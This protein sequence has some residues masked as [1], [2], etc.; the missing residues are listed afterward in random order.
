VL[1]VLQEAAV[2]IETSHRSDIAFDST[3]NVYVTW[4]WVWACWQPSC[5]SVH[6]RWRKFGKEGEGNGELRGPS[7]IEVSEE[8]MVYVAKRD[9][10]RI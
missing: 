10:H 1:L 8:N 6:S 7:R 2:D 3:G 4:V 9:N 5:T